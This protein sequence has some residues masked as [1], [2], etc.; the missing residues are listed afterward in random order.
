VPLTVRETESTTESQSKGQLIEENNVP[1][2]VVS[3]FGQ[4]LVHDCFAGN[5]PR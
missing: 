3:R 2:E 5:P 4:N 1:P